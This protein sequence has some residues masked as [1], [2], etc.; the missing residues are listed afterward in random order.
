[1]NQ[2]GVHVIDA[3]HVSWV[4]YRVRHEKFAN[5]TKTKRE[6]THITFLCKNEPRIDA[7]NLIHRLQTMSVQYI[8]TYAEHTMY[9]Y[10][11]VCLCVCAN[12]KREKVIGRSEEIK[13]W[14]TVNFSV[15]IFS[16]MWSSHSFPCFGCSIFPVELILSGSYRSNGISQDNNSEL[17]V[18]LEMNE[19]HY[20]HSQ[21]NYALRAPAILED[22]AWIASSFFLLS[23]FSHFFSQCFIAMLNEVMCLFAI[24][25]VIVLVSST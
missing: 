17:K 22:N 25:I 19:L 12:E 5:I 16:S 13:W 21:K 4:S 10:H 6:S 23:F 3:T 8:H 14:F 7:L 18:I 24:I 11:T 15:L 1:M 20:V 9:T 2:N